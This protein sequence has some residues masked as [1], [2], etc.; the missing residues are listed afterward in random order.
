MRILSVL[1]LL[2]ANLI[3]F[4]V[5]GQIQTGEFPPS[6]FNTSE[7]A[8]PKPYAI[9]LADPN[10]ESKIKED[11]ITDE[12]KD[13]AWRF[14]TLLPVNYTL[15][16]SGE[17][18]P[19]DDNGTSTWKLQL[20]FQQAKSINLNFNDFRLSAG[21]RL[22]V[23]NENYTDVLGALTASNN[24][25]DRLFSIRPMK[26]RSITLELIVPQNEMEQNVLSINELVYGYRSIHDKV[27]KV[28]QS[29]GNCNINVNCQEGDNW[30]DVKRAVAMVTTVSNT[31]FCTATLIN[32]VRQDTLPYMLTAAHCVVRN[33]SIFI[34]GY[35]SASCNPNTNGT[36]GNSISGST[37][38]AITVNF[39][40][41]F[42][43][44]EL[45]SRPPA[46]YNVYYAGWNNQNLASTKSV[47][48]HHPTGDVKKLSVDKDI[49]TN[50]GYYAAGVTHWQVSNWEKGTTESGS[51]GSALFD[52][53]QRIIGQLHGGDASCNN[54]VQDY[55]GKFSR[56]WDF[57]TDTLRQ[58][59]YWLDPDAT[60][61]LVLDG[62]DPNPAAFSID[63]DVLDIDGI[64]D[65]ECTQS[66]QATFR[67]KN[68]GNNPVDS[69]YVDYQLNGNPV[70]SIRYANSTN[71]QQ[72]ATINSPNISPTNG[73]NLLK[74]TA[75]TAGIIDQ[76]LTN[77]TDSIAFNINTSTSD[78]LYISLKT[79][80]YGS[81]TSWQLEDLTSGNI[82]H[83]SP[84]YPDVNGGVTYH[85]SLCAYNSCFRFSIFDSQ[86]DGFNDPSG[87]FGNGYLLITNKQLDTLFFENN[88]TTALSTDTFC[89]QF[90]TS[91]NEIFSNDNAI[92][93]FPN[94]INAGE[95]LQLNSMHNFSLNL[96][97]IQGQLI[98]EAQGNKFNLPKKLA[99]GIYFLEIRTLETNRIL[100]IK[101]VLIQ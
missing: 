53:N 58:L 22:F 99:S 18:S 70:Q 80:D 19:N 11:A 74:I 100:G 50:S 75:R 63:L 38:K 54:R 13:I 21:A 48:I 46:S 33:N 86:G 36:L 5:Q 82:L 39:G 44:R 65:F 49:V 93:V 41:D 61:T 81:E 90:S 98:A 89:E 3:C 24:K 84:G 40:S 37:R 29:S 9:Q 57:T 88:F 16:N 67:V 87:N 8:G 7:E 78:F 10:V 47:C 26:G 91:L 71:R 42:E 59:K 27:Q 79:D 101:K 72:I 4:F 52:V 31:R 28:F 85:D 34:F 69:F 92:S 66:V 60:G 23:S 35:E 76:N 95:I 64:K 56:S 68:I 6:F 51:S 73:I 20:S 1:V 2:L 17:W 14:G 94:P 32:N 15:T 25:A 96:R 62:L 55:F 45:S 12:Y 43:L 83:L 97:N 30:Q 77:N